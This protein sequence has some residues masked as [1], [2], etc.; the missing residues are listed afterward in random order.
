VVVLNQTEIARIVR[1]AGRPQPPDKAFW[2]QQAERALMNHL[3]E[4]AALPPDGRLIINRLPDDSVLQARKW[5][6]A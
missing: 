4:Q 1:L 2:Q 6:S 5:K 3:F